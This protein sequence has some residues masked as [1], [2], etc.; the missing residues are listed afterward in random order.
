[1]HLKKRLETVA[2]VVVY[3]LVKDEKKDGSVDHEKMKLLVQTVDEI[4]AWLE[5]E[6]WPKDDGIKDGGEWIVGE[7]KGLDCRAGALWY[8]SGGETIRLGKGF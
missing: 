1:M 7:G 5:E 8:G 6:Y 2:V 4:N 3:Q